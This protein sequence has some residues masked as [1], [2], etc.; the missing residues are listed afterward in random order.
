R[1]STRHG[2]LGLSLLRADLLG[3]G[4][5][6]PRFPGR[7][8]GRHGSSPLRV[9]RANV[10]RRFQLTVS[11]P[12]PRCRGPGPPD[13]RTRGPRRPW[14]IVPLHRIRPLPDPG[15]LERFKTCPLPAPPP[16]RVTCIGPEGLPAATSPFDLEERIGFSGPYSLGF[17][18]G[19]P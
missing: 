16:L 6:V 9:T 12:G 2:P 17:G 5:L 11:F 4:R 18:P 10:A 1:R 8:L 14:T 15:P 19:G 13:G 3:R 7:R